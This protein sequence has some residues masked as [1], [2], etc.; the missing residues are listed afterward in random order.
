MDGDRSK[1]AVRDLKK[2]FPLQHSR[3]IA[4]RLV[5]DG[6]GVA[7]NVRRRFADMDGQPGGYWQA[8]VDAC[9]GDSSIKFL[10]H[11][12]YFIRAELRRRHA[13]ACAQ[14]RQEWLLHRCG[15]E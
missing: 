8:T 7:Q 12:L 10:A 3:T 5:S 11:D 1:V 9:R 13:L 6:T 15:R 4:T 2:S 14:A